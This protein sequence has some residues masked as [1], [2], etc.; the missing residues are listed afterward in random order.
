MRA[1]FS[2][3]IALASLLAIA[4]PASAADKPVF[5]PV[6][7]WVK[8]VARPAKLPPPDDAA[9]HILIADEQAMLEPGQRSVYSSF[10]IRIQTPQG[11]AAG[12]ISLP[13]RPETDELTVHKLVIRRKDQV[14]DVL[15]S[16]QEFTVIRREQNLESAMLDGVL[17]A[18]IQPEGLQV[19]DILEFAMTVTAR[20][21]VTKDHV[22]LIAGAWNGARIGRAHFRVQWPST[23]AMHYRTTKGLPEPKIVKS[24]NLTGI[25][26]TVDSIEPLDPPRG[27]PPRYRIGRIAEFT[28]FASWADLASLLAPLY[29]K[30]AVLPEQGPLRIEAERIRAA[31]PDPKL[32][33]E[34]ALALVQNRIRYVLRAMGDG[35]LV[36]TD[37]ATSWAR[38]YGDCKAKTALLLALLHD[39]GIEA[40]PVAVSSR[41]GDGIDAR[42]PMVSLF[43]HVLVRAT[44][45]GK[46]YWLDGTRLG[47][48]NLDRI[49]TPDV[50]W[51]LPLLPAGA[52][53]QR[54][55]PTAL[56]VPSRSIAIHIDAREGIVLPAPTRIETIFRGD[57]AVQF[58]LAYSNLSPNARDRALREYWKSQHDFIDAT[59]VSSTFDAGTG[60]FKLVL[61]G[62]ARMDWSDGSYETDGTGLGWKADFS[63]EPGPDHDAPFTVAYPYFVRL[64]ETILL[65]PGF[66][67]MKDSSKADVNQTVAGVEYRRKAS[68]VDNVFSVETSE[69]SIAP[70]FPYQDAAEAQRILREL[71]DYAVRVRRPRNYRPTD[72]EIAA[73]LAATPESAA[74]YM[75]R[76]NILLDRGRFDEA[77]KDFDQAIQLDPGNGLALANRAVAKVWKQDYAAAARDIEAAAAIAPRNAV[78]FCARGLLAE[79]TG[80]T[81]EAVAAYTSAL[82]IEPRNAFALG[83]RA[84]SRRG[85]GDRDAALSDSA[86]AIR[87]KPDWIDLYLMRANIFR[88]LGKEEEAL[89]EAVAVE[90]ANQRNSYAITVAAN[91]YAAFGKNDEAM[92]AFDRAIAIKPEAYLYLN[93]AMQRPKQDIAARRADLQAGLALD[94]KDGSIIAAM[95]G[96]EAD[97]GNSQTA[98]AIYTR[99]LAATPDDIDMLV[100][101]G[102][103]YARAGDRG[104]ADK[105]FAAARVTI[106]K[107]AST[108]PI[109]ATYLNNMCWAKAT[110]GISLESA[111]VDCNAALEKAPDNPGYLDSRG[112]VH[113]RL[114]QLDA[115]IDDYDRALA[116]Y[117]DMAS[118]LFGRAVAWSRMG[119]RIKADA[120]LAAAAVADKDIRSRFEKYGLTLQN[121]TPSAP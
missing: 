114:G 52:T 45:A 104:R 80:K 56:D 77:I 19:G 17:T 97:R 25:E 14:I 73:T 90:A 21:P 72:K 101:R 12:N 5:G 27:A 117:P 106:G 55:L 22:E 62:L 16:G 40:I 81:A 8:P 94:P 84:L 119:D 108:A 46:T 64:T 105:D 49:T 57:E 99:A 4:G 60:E 42:L 28:D 44:I 41:S 7:A 111:L 91:I 15:E 39:L 86:E 66:A 51:G 96:L 93:R 110:A 23:A 74:G 95:A 34:A 79:Q 35:G 68:L 107:A 32:R 69:R 48:S 50:G 31:T 26:L 20:D 13:W 18:N 36:P 11:L 63:R 9:M 87:L 43:D 112:L 121:E 100:A 85:R 83:H 78:L 47:D 75:G 54:M 2:I 92:R 53:L 59:S 30:A 33:A 1:G 10:A 6:P 103:A 76:A 116:Q 71:A 24:G 88:N 70:E 37:A 67:E 58:N 82:E 89:K 102:I 29:A 115:A 38:R 98:I 118:S 61:D 3:R 65:P 120:D 109:A 113:L